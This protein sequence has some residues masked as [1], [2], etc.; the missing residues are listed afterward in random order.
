MLQEATHKRKIEVI[1]RHDSRQ[2][3]AQSVADKLQRDIIDMR[4]MARQE[5]NTLLVP[6]R[7]LRHGSQSQHLLTTNMNTYPHQHLP[8]NLEKYNT[9]LDDKPS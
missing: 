7:L 6:L 2:S 5:D 8:Q 1:S 4:P 3:K 9:H